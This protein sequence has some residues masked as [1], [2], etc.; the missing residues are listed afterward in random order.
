MR[1]PKFVQ[2]Y[3]RINNPHF[4]GIVL[5]INKVKIIAKME[6]VQIR[7][8]DF[9]RILDPKMNTT[10]GQSTGQ[11]TTGTHGFSPILFSLNAMIRI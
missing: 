10:Y 4:R 2:S 5:F 7:K 1:G 3:F 9:S 8:K 6:R 11:K